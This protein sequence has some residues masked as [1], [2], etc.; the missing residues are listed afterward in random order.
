MY[1]GVLEKGIDQ[2]GFSE[3][4]RLFHEKVQRKKR[5][6]LSPSTHLPM[7]PC[8][9]AASSSPGTTPSIK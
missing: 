3:E 4:H 7:K 1:H 9:N 6:L 8:P 2:A 5:K